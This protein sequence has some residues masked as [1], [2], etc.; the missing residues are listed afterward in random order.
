MAARGWEV[1]GGKEGSIWMVL[2]LWDTLGGAGDDVA[3]SVGDGDELSSAGVAHQ[4]KPHPIISNNLQI[5][6]R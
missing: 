3:M 2:Q 1:S 5:N 4:E 6:C